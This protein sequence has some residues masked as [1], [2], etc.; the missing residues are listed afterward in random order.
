VAKLYVVVEGHGE[1]RAALNLITRLWRDLALPEIACADPPIRGIALH[2]KAGM[3]K[4]CEILRS[5]RDCGRALI[6]RDEDDGCPAERGPEAARWIGEAGLLFPVAL[7]LAHREFEAWFLPCVH[8]MAGRRLID[9]NG[10]SRAGIREG[11]KFSGNP[12]QLRGVKEWLSGQFAD[13]KSYKPTLDQL[14]LTR[15]LSF[16]VLRSSQMPSFGTLERSLR[17]L[18]TAIGHAVYPQSA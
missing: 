2:T 6:L 12:E 15:L 16:D 18:A 7:V 17:F 1:V 4:A 11:S 8:L 5:K 10:G 14:A 9:P 13:G 3:L